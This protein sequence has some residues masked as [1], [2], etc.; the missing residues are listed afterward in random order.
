MLEIKYK[1]SSTQELSSWDWWANLWETNDR[2]RVLTQ[3]R[4]EFWVVFRENSYPAERTH[5]FGSWLEVRTLRQGPQWYLY[6]LWYLEPLVQSAW[7]VWNHRKSPNQRSLLASLECAPP[8]PLRGHV[9]S[10]STRPSYGKEW[11]KTSL[12]WFSR[13]SKVVLISTNSVWLRYKSVWLP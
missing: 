6:H 2:S 10:S 8:P 11:E 3:V 12:S 13:C 5:G 1:P 7:K 9:H 4:H